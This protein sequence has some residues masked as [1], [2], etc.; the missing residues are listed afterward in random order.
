MCVKNLAN[1]GDN[2]QQDLE[3]SA[4]VFG[5]QVCQTVTKQK[6]SFHMVALCFDQYDDQENL[7]QAQ[8]KLT[9]FKFNV[10]PAFLTL[11]RT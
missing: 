1:I 6:L 7:T 9:L 4:I 8:Q 5:L 2:N 10:K 3:K 11:C